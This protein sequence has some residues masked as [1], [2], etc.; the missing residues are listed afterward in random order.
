MRREEALEL[1]QNAPRGPERSNVDKL[2]SKSGIFL[3]MHNR[4]VEMPY[5]ALLPDRWAERIN[6][7]VQDK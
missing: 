7:I 3:V 5:N 6:K 2:Y 1:L 4:I